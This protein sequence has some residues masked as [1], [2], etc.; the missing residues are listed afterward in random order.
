[1]L[2]LEALCDPNLRRV[3]ADEGIE[4]RSFSQLEQFG[5]L[6]GACA[7]MRNLFRTLERLAA[8]SASVMILGES[9][10]GKELVANTIHQLSDRKGRASHL[11]YF[12]IFHVRADAAFVFRD[13]PLP[14]GV[15]GAVGEKE[16]G[17]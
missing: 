2:E 5:A 4:L 3:L 16:R 8:T 15:A 13:V 7:A 9:G 1:M 12:R 14:S 17:E 10:S 11:R 6:F